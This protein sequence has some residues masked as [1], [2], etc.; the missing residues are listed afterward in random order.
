MLRRAPLIGPVAAIAGTCAVLALVTI[1][2]A[3]AVADTISGP[4]VRTPASE[5]ATIRAGGPVAVAPTSTTQGFLGISTG[6]TT[7]AALDGSAADPDAPF[8]SLVRNLSP[9]APPVLR[10]GGVGT[11][12]SWW[13]I[14]GIRERYLYELTPRWAAGVRALLEA[15]GGK[16]IL[17]V[18][19]EEDSKP[20]ARTEVANFDRY[21][22]AS[23]ID[24][25]ELGN[26]P[27]FFPI[28]LPKGHPPHDYPYKIAHYGKE[29]SSIASALGGAP[30]AGPASGAP[31]WL[32]HLGTILSDIPSR[33]KLVTTHAYPLKHCSRLAHLSVSDLFT[34]SS[35]NGLADPIHATVRA[36]AAHHKPLR[37]DELNG[38][39]CGGEAGISNSFGEALWALNVLP[40]LWRTG[41]QGV[42]FQTVNGDLNQLITAKHT[43][44][45]WRVSVQPEYYGLLAFADAAPAGSRL[46]RISNLHLSHFYQ[47]A[48]RAPNGSER[49]VLTN[50]GSAA[51]TI[52]VTVSGTRGT[53]SV[54]LLSATSLSATGGTTLA[55]RRLSPRT[56]Q[57]IG[58][59]RV[60]RV[61]PNARG[62]Y[63]VR[64]PPHAAAILTLSA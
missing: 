38:V 14:P 6:L 22:G 61:R 54:S 51:R 3:S 44:A 7:I 49:V 48:V 31:H 5:R 58:T 18:N 2:S 33:L 41:V 64:V 50:V 25:F 9:G 56:G 16:A 59:P 21:V 12:D 17:G 8:A 24:A 27:E 20:I 62:V 36:A 10:L 42:N 15:V 34:R 53:G 47:F 35:I 39:S 60:T 40:A 26:E 29:F 1:G 30:L 32:S 46:L 43:A 4:I 23:L 28:A 19:L 57:L 52:G 55:G 63:A 11:D 45:G 13:P 37:V